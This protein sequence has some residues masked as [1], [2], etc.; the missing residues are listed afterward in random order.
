MH[1]Y[2]CAVTYTYTHTY[3]Y[4]WVLSWKI[5]AITPAFH[6]PITV[7]TFTSSSAL[8]HYCAIQL[9]NFLMICVWYSGSDF[10]ASNSCCYGMDGPGSGDIPTRPA[11]ARVWMGQV[12]SGW[13][14]VVWCGVVWCGMMWCGV[15]WCGMVWY[16]VVWCDVMWCGVVYRTVRAT[17]HLFLF[18]QNEPNLTFINSPTHLNRMP[19]SVQSSVCTTV[20]RICFTTS[21]QALGN[22]LFALGKLGMSIVLLFLYS[23]I[24]FI[25][26]LRMTLST[27][28][29]H[30]THISPFQ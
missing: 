24:V 30:L 16:D 14:G 11:T 4:T 13:C 18:V 9:F 5:N 8:M 21:P 22:T 28:S 2:T 12:S 27:S 10:Q 1:T 19:V 25:E 15:V 17:S 29:S 23:C 6:T 26:F 3:T 20:C 7:T